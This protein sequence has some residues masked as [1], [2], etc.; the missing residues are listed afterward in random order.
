[1]EADKVIRMQGRGLAILRVVVGVVFL[2]HGLEKLLVSGFAGVAGF[3]GE[4]GVPAAGL[5]AGL[6]TLLEIFGG[7]A[8]ILG[9]FTRVVAIPLA[10]DMLT[11]TLLVHVPNGF[12]VQNGGYELTLLLLAGSVALA[13]AGP[14]SAALGNALAARTKNPAHARL[15]R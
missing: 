13:V 15:V 7:A 6:V 2:A 5:F 11:A 9:L 8:L 4:L 10:A 3:F 12:F 14:G 1:M